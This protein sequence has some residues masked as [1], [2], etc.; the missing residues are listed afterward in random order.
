MVDISSS[1]SFSVA[2][3]YKA[4]LG[5]NWSGFTNENG[6]GLRALAAYLIEVEN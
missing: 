1:G 6:G 5:E 2:D 4:L 3:I